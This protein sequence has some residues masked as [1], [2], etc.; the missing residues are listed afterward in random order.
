MIERCLLPEDGH[1]LHYTNS[2]VRPFEKRMILMI[3]AAGHASCSG[4]NKKWLHEE[5]E[6]EEEG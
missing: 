5:T 1:M 2:M 4:C 6:I 3:H